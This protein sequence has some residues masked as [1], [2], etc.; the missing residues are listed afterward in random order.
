MAIGLKSSNS[1]EYALS[2]QKNTYVMS[3]NVFLAYPLFYKHWY[4]LTSLFFVNKL[5]LIAPFTC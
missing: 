1:Q 2:F 3:H 5:L 4:V